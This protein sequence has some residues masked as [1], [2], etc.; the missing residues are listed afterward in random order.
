M[1]G[2]FL[3]R[4]NAGLPRSRCIL[5]VFFLQVALT[6][7]VILAAPAPLARKTRRGPSVTDRGSAE[8]TAA[9]TR[10]L[11]PLLG[12]D[13]SVESGDGLAAFVESPVVPVPGRVLK[14]SSSSESIS[15]YVSC[16]DP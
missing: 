8:V 12:L 2:V 4:D 10:L 13:G 16:Y 1:T 14:I 9:V 7:S 15:L 6:D 5:V 3:E 11:L